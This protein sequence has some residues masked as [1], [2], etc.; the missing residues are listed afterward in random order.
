M[1]RLKP[2]SLYIYLKNGS[3]VDQTMEKIKTSLMDE[4]IDVVNFKAYVSDMME[5]IVNAMNVLCVVLLIA[6]VFVIAMTLLLLIKTQLVRDRK[7]LGIYKALGYT[8]G[9]LMMQTTM[10]YTPVVF[11]GAVIGCIVAWFGINPSVI[12]CLSAFGIKKCNMNINVE[13][14]IGIVIMIS[15]WAQMI[16]V[17]LFP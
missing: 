6:V 1:K 2:N 13:Y 15:L 10:S 5:S 14:L 9:Q 12:V 7:T 17:L 3:N 8:T 16:V 4:T 11:V